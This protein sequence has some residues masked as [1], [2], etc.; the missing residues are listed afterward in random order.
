MASFTSPRSVSYT[1]LMMSFI[2][3]LVAPLSLVNA[4]IVA[5]GIKKRDEISSTFQKLEYIW[6]EYDVYAKTLE[7]K[8]RERPE[9][10]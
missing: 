8:G 2:D 9:I 1:H 3:S 7:S 4:L 10:E 5:V 6:D